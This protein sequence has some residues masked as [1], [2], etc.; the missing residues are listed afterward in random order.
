[1]AGSTDLEQLMLEY[2]NEAR[3]DPLATR[4][5]SSHP[6]HHSPRMIRTF[7]TP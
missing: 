4:R 1:M 7:G 6:I 3:I 2:I 5:A